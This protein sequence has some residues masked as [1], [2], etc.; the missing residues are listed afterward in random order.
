MRTLVVGTLSAALVGCSCLNSPQA[1]LEGCTS[2][3]CYDRT[4]AAGSPLE[5]NPPPF[6]PNPPPASKTKKTAR[7]AAAS[8]GK[9]SGSAEPAEEKQ[10]SS[11]I[12]KPEPSSS[13]QSDTMNKAKLTTISMKTNASSETSDVADLVLKKAKITIATKMEDPTSAEF[14]DMKRAM[15][16]N[17]FGQPV[18]TICGHVKGKKISGEE[19]GEKPFLYLVKEDEAYV[20]DNN[21]ESAATTAYRNICLTLDMRGKDLRPLAG[22]TDSGGLSMK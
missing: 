17:T 2:L 10:I 19:T 22:G 18:D 8:S 6:T 9:I 3:A 7:V 13:R 14:A 21:P 11:T 5:L 12:L 1:M 15:R 4:A 20:V 16:K